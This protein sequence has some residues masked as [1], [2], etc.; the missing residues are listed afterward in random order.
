M[1]RRSKNPKVKSIVSQ[2]T[3][4]EDSAS[5][6]SA[7]STHFP[8]LPHSSPLSAPQLSEKEQ[9]ILNEILCLELLDAKSLHTQHHPLL[10]LNQALLTPNDVV[11]K[12]STG[13]KNKRKR[14]THQHNAV[15]MQTFYNKD[16]FVK[17]LHD[18]IDQ[19]REE[20]Q[21]IQESK[22]DPVDT[23]GLCREWEENRWTWRD[24]GQ[25]LLGM[26]DARSSAGKS[27]K[28]KRRKVD[29]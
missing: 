13:K 2:K 25:D 20:M 1:T 29:K 6:T 8:T 17:N 5:S 28:R 7:P 3:T 10:F 4:N 24:I 21:E 16:H 14:P 9:T 27:K 23:T 19:Q 18:I 22:D 15:S 12:P 11:P 26:N